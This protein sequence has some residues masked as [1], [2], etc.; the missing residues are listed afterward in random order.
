LQQIYVE[1]Y[2]RNGYSRFMQVIEDII[3]HP[4]RNAIEKR[5]RIIEFFDKWGAEA[6]KEAH[7]KSRA[8]IYLWK[9]HLKAS[10]GKLS[11]L[12]PH[13][14]APLHRRK[15]IVHPF[16]ESFIVEYRTNH[17]GVD[18]TTITPALAIACRHAG[19]KQV[20]ESTVGRII[21][22][23]KEKG[24]LPRHC[25]I[26]L[27]GRSGEI[28][29]IKP[30]Q[31]TRK[32]R[33]K[34][35][36]PRRPGDLVQMDTVSI[37]TAGV[38]RYIFTGLD[39]STRFAFAHTYK[40]NSSAN[41]R[42]FLEKFLEVAPFTVRNIQTDNGSEFAKYFADYCQRRRLVHFYN[43]PR[44]PQSNG[45]LERFNRT[46][47]EQFAEWHIDEID[48]TEVFNRPLMDYLIWYNTEKPHRGIGKVP[49]L[50]YYLDNFITPP[51]KSNILWT[52]TPSC[53]W[54]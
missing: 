17:P 9:Q 49:P 40:S 21:H 35:F 20:S 54:G 28:H 34:G 19:I 26:R 36:Y 15:R 46:I 14:K 39:V 13:H 4:Q 43:Y 42:D 2:Y 23:L 32:T 6:T 41:G 37:F 51:E 3:G 12:A 8:T 18:K 50:R 11:S 25:R 38:K 7:T 53:K 48:D 31:S 27:N 24:R 5:L 16:I 45:H 33:R 22:D 29:E 47:Q 30:R 1:S 52:L 10:G 44:H